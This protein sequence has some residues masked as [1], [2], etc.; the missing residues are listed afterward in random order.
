MFTHTPVLSVAA[1]CFEC[2]V[3]L[4]LLLQL[5]QVLGIQ[6]LQDAFRVH[7]VQLVILDFLVVYGF[8]WVDEAQRDD[9][10]IDG[11]GATTLHAQCSLPL[12]LLQYEAILIGDP[13][14]LC[15][16]R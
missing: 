3:V 12:C 1:I 15:S 8:R 6:A 14:L 4:D 2:E 7:N 16:I 13:G 5:R 9:E 11:L 10:P